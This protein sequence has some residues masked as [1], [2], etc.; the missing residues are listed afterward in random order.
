[1][2]G[3]IRDYR[4][5]FDLACIDHRGKP[6]NPARTSTLE[7]KE[8]SICWGAEFCIRGGPERERER[9]WSIQRRESAS[10]IKRLLWTSTR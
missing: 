6:E 3:F 5:V 9:P 10:M 1:M 8:G 4:C 2:I 7:P